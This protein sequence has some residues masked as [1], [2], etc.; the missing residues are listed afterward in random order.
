MIVDCGFLVRGLVVVSPRFPWRTNA[1][2][3]SGAGP[4]WPGACL[5][6]SASASSPPR[7]S[8]FGSES[9]R[10]PSSVLNHSSLSVSRLFSIS[11]IIESYSFW[12]MKAFC[13]GTKHSWNHPHPPIFK[14]LQIRTVRNIGLIAPSTDKWIIWCTYTAYDRRPLLPYVVIF[15]NTEIVKIFSSNI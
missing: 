15:I 6:T 2:T 11:T 4:W 7:P 9:A 5:C 13:Y 12:L 3:S 14:Y 1:P 10:H 8:F